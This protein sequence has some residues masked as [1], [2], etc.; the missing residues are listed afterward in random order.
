MTMPGFTAEASLNVPTEFYRALPTIGGQIQRTQVFPQ[1]TTLWFETEGG[2]H[3][4]VCALTIHGGDRPPTF[5]CA[6]LDVCE[7]HPF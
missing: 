7:Y 4:K 6:T 5:E 1:M 2:C 3:P